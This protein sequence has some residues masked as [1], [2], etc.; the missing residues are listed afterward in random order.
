MVQPKYNPQE[1]L[2]RVKLMM[3]YD[4]SK[5]STENK[6][7]IEE[8]TEEKSRFSCIINYYKSRNVP[9]E[10]YSMDGYEAVGVT[11]SPKLNWDFSYSESQGQQWLELKKGDNLK[12][13]GI[14]NCSGG[15]NFTIRDIN[16][17]KIILDTTQPVE[18]PPKQT[19]Q[20]VAQPAQTQPKADNKQGTPDPSKPQKLKPKDSPLGTTLEDTKIPKRSCVAYVD[21]LFEAFTRWREGFDTNKIN[22]LRGYVQRCMDDHFPAGSRQG[23]WGITGLGGSKTDQKLLKLSVCPM[24]FV[25]RP[26]PDIVSS[27]APSQS[28]P[29][30]I[31]RLTRKC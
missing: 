27:P 12:K 1:A 24:K 21:H 20:P 8:Q 18:T 13:K 5:T 26:D 17:N 30:S 6:K 25:G 2:E 23:N 11:L 10:E 14:W 16:S 9:Y 15:S 3:N 22:E 29:D 28:A 31:F 4:L 19:V 7:V